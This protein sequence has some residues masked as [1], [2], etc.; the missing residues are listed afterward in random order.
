MILIKVYD[1]ELSTEKKGD[2]L[3]LFYAVSIP[4]AFFLL[5]AFRSKTFKD[6][7][8]VDVLFGLFMMF[9]VLVV[10]FY[11]VLNTQG[12]WVTDVVLYKSKTSEAQI[13]EETYELG[14]FGS[15]GYRTIE[16]EKFLYY[17]YKI[18]MIDTSNID[19]VKWE[20]V[21]KY[22]RGA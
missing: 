22:L 1:L 20:P 21:F 12:E 19:S 3:L 2:D 18:E 4:I 6:F 17:F 10:G 16:K 8:W 14:V 9:S 15:D 7:S 5:Y 13:V 11:T